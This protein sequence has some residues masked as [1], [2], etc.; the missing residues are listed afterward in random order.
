MVNYFYLCVLF[1]FVE[2]KKNYKLPEGKSD[3]VNES[4]VM[5]ETAQAISADVL[6]DMT[7]SQLESLQ[8]ALNQLDSGNYVPH[9]EVMKMSKLWLQ[10]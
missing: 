9:S 2:M 5:Y 10:I 6:D 4:E 8:M 1:L 3:T 7:T